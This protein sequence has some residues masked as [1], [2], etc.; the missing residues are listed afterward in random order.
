MESSTAMAPMQSAGSTTNR[1]RDGQAEARDASIKRIVSEGTQ[2]FEAW[3]EKNGFESFDP[4]DI[5]GTKYG[6]FARRVYYE[7]GVV[8]LP[9]IAPILLMDLACPSARSLFVS[10]DRFGT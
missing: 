4:Y 5:W 10:K 6:L 1:A 8:G 9:L 3:L 7:K 2:R